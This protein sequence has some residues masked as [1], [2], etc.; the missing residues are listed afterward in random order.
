MK[1]DRCKVPGEFRYITFGDVHLGHPTTP[2]KHTLKALTHYIN[3]DLIKSVDM[4]VIEGD[5]FD[6]L[7]HAEDDNLYLIHRWMTFLLFKC[8]AYNTMLRIVEGTPLHDRH[9]SRFFVEQKNNA[10]IDVDL[11]YAQELSIE[12]IEKL[13]A[14]FLYVPDKCRPHTDDILRDVRV[15]LKDK[16]LTQVDFAIMHGAFSYQLPDVVT[17]PTHDERS[18]LDMVKYF[19]MIGHVHIRTSYERI[20]AAGSFDRHSHGDEIEKGFYDVTVRSSGNHSIVFKENKLAKRYDTIECHGL[21]T[22]ALN[23]KIRQKLSTLPK[24]SSIKLRCNAHDAAT[25]DIKFYRQEFPQYEWV[26]PHIEKATKPK[27][28]VANALASF[29]LSEFIPIDPHS[30]LNLIEPELLKQAKG[31]VACVARCK[32]LMGDLIKA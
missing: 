2:T 8:A 14:H 5:L 13:D 1:T 17:E 15:L 30:I 28:S 21:D 25:G 31:S 16:G 6:H 11:H 18:Y 26:T 20:L 10:K 29:D 27:E 32:Q 4:I 3:D 12:Y 19:I 9:Q 24:G 23:V 7:L 22:K